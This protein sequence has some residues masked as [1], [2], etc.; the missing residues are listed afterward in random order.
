MCVVL[1]AVTG[2]VTAEATPMVTLRPGAGSGGA[3]PGATVGWGYEIVND[4]S[5]NW[6]VI[7]SFNSDGFQ[8][9]SLNDFLF[10]YPIVAPGATITMPYL[11]G[12]QGLAE[13][14]WDVTAPDGF[15]NSGAF[16]IGAEFWDDEPFLGGLFVS[17]LP[18]FTAVYNIST[19]SA[20][21]PVP[22]P[23]SL[24][25]VGTGLAGLA[26]GRRRFRK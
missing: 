20:P 10:D 24:L 22:E 8:Y 13:F 6:L 21:A 18:D 5:D 3:S 4:D 16:T 14:T 17:T 11:A 2:A 9:G 26:A 12:L 25:L 15:T 1:I 19:A 23:A 7:S